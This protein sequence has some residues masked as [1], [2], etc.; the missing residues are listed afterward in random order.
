MNQ[1]SIVVT[2]QYSC[3]RYQNHGTLD[4]PKQ[5]WPGVAGVA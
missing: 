1:L 3:H 5:R 2:P 4:G